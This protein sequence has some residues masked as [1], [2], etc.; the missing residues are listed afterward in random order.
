MT[1]VVSIITPIRAEEDIHLTWLGEAIKSVQQQT[2]S[3]WEMVI[4]DDNSPLDLREVAYQF[5][6]DGRIRWRKSKGSG[7][8]AARNNG[9][10]AATAE[11]L[12]PL[13]AD[14]RLAANALVKFLEAWRKGGSDAGLVYSS[15]LMFAPDMQ[16][17]HNAPEY[18]FDGLLRATFMCVGCL[19][20][21]S[22]WA[23]IGGWRV[24]MEEGLEDWEYW[25]SM[26]EAGVCG[27]RVGDVLYHYRRHARGRLARVKTDTESWS[28]SQQKI[29]QLH[30]ETYNGR[31]PVGC[32]GGARRSRRHDKPVQQTQVQMGVP[33]GSGVP[34]R[35]TGKQAAKFMITGKP[36]GIK[37]KVMGIGSQ[38]DIS[39]QD[40]PFFLNHD[41]FQKVD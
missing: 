3:N 22:D 18:S 34:I 1:P 38:F 27:Y 16:K 12:L 6:E 19:H 29:R 36:S 8:G 28:K 33:K 13:D 24:D 30:K 23:K 17:V 20:R 5:R 41:C 10:E 32:C 11:L 37:Y 25:I 15:I 2:E 26:G 35:Y 14:D 21:K 9:A 4:V 31:R 39:P 7:V 40:L